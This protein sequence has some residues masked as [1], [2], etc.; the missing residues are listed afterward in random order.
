MVKSNELIKKIKSYES[1]VV[2]L[3]NFFVSDEIKQMIHWSEICFAN[4]EGVSTRLQSDKANNND[5][6]GHPSEPL[7]SEIS[8]FLKNKFSKIINKD[9]KLNIEFD[10]AF[11]ANKKPYGIHTDSGYDPNEL[12]YKQGIIP[13][14]N[15]PINKKTH[16][17][18]LRQKCYHSSSFPNIKEDLKAQK[19]VEHLDFESP[20]SPEVY[21]TYWEECPERSLQM[22][23]FT[24]DYP[25]EWNINDTVIWDR[26]HI[27]CSSDFEATGVNFKLGL[28]WIS[29]IKQH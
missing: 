2:P 22:Q 17:V 18:I 4:E 13:L 19:H 6:T 16:T 28:M 25:F 10:V 7:K 9:N 12:I 27:H 21:K 24:I 3:I 8:A 26:S 11:H 20:M 29:R 23:G 14:I 1:P 15:K 5:I